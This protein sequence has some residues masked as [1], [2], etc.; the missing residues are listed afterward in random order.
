MVIKKKILE[1][2]KLNPSYLFFTTIIFLMLSFSSLKITNIPER[3]QSLRGVKEDLILKT[4]EPEP[5]SIF[6]VPTP[7]HND[8]LTQNWAEINVSIAEKNLSTFKFNWNDENYSIYGDNLVFG[9]NLDENLELGESSTFAYDFSKYKNHGTLADGAQWVP[10]EY[11]KAVS[12]DGTGAYLD[13]GTDNS[14]KSAHGTIQFWFKT[15]AFNENRDIINI[16]ENGYNDYLLVRRTDANKIYVCIEDDNDVK[17]YVTTSRAIIDTDFHHIIITQSGDGIRIFIDGKE[18][19]LSGVNSGYWTSHLTSASCWIGKGYWSNCIGAI[20]EVMMYSEA[21]EFLNDNAVWSEEGYGADVNPTGNPIGG[22]L[23]YSEIIN[24]GDADYFV[25][26]KAEL[27]SALSSENAE[28]IINIDDKVKINMTVEEGLVIPNN[29]TLASGRGNGG[30]EGALLHYDTDQSDAQSVFPLFSASDYVRVTGLRL[31]GPCNRTDMTDTSCGIRS[32][33]V[34][35]VEI[36]NCELYAWGYT[37]AYY[38]RS[39]GGYVHHNYIHHNQRS[40]LGYGVSVNQA[41]VLIEANLM[42]SCRHHIASTGRPGSFYEA[43]YNIVLESA[44]GNSHC[45]DMHS[46]HDFEKNYRT[47]HWRFDNGAGGTATDDALFGVN[48]ATLT[49]IDLGTCWVDGK[50]QYGLKFDGLDDYVNGGSDS[51]L[52]ITGDITIEAWINTTVIPEDNNQIILSK[53]TL[54]SSQSYSLY[55]NGGDDK[56]YFCI[57]DGVNVSWTMPV[58]LQNNW[59]HVLGTYNGAK[60]RLFYDGEFKAEANYVGSVG[61]N[62]DDLCI[63]ATS[64]GTLLF[65]GIIDEV[66]IYEQILDNDTIYRHFEGYTDIAGNYIKVH[67]NTFKLISECAIII[68]GISYYTSEIYRNRFYHDSPGFAIQQS[69]A[70]GN[71]AIYDNCFKTANYH[72]KD[73]SLKKINSSQWNF[74]FNATDLS[75]GTYTYYSWANDSYGNSDYTY[76]RDDDVYYNSSNPRIFK[77]VSS[78]LL[79]VILISPEDKYKDID[80]V[81]V[82]KCDTFNNILLKNVTIFIWNSNGLFYSNTKIISGI[83][84]STTWNLMDLS[85][86]DFT[87]NCLAY[88]IDGRSAWNSANFSFIVDTGTNNDGNGGD[89]F[90]LQD[91][92]TFIATIG[93]ISFIIIVISIIFIKKS[94]TSSSKH[95]KAKTKKAILS[96]RKHKNQSEIKSEQIRSATEGL[97]F[98]CVILKIFRG[99]L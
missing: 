33:D 78:P 68:R 45:F 9:M 59:H 46:A 7:T 62:T 10:G 47:S 26:N 25:I 39:T 88:D 72:L 84:N 98:L 4:S 17:A 67:H 37:P 2:R 99:F 23:G 20:D 56:I 36:D 11:G 8:N 24:Q 65:N 77:I 57:D 19:N 49:N 94:G 71:L 51:S 87:W 22:E 73:I 34:D 60:L 86:G 66:I 53:G 15:N 16:F 92:L 31:R 30:S 80:G 82:F 5:I 64:S 54:S 74:F 52:D 14:F 3:S 93:I 43:R 35:N 96:H 41:E 28:E 1:S 6:E 83:Y 91:F 75:A 55:L 32:Q 85:D 89:P 18:E 61:T 29:V 44:S 97:Y 48:D 69:N 63:G 76:G 90:N 50:I 81:I 79:K 40:G 70:F 95:K 58:G 12:F 27:L 21:V 38:Y 13:C 42:D